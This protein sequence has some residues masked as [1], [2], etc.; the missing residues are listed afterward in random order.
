MKYSGWIIP[1]ITLWI[2]MGCAVA[3][4][5]TPSPVPTP[6]SSPTVMVPTPTGSMATK[7][8]NRNVPANVPA[9]PGAQDLEGPIQFVW[10]GIEDVRQSTPASNWTYY[11]CNVSPSIL[12]VFYRRWMS[13][14]QYQWVLQHWEERPTATLGV[15]Y[16]STSTPGVP[17]RWLYLWFL[18]DDSAK[19]SSYL[20]SAWWEAA[21]S[22]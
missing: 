18:P 5:P 19:Q 1:V 6:A 16:S 7:I 13:E 4:A 12:A 9:C 21:K 15:F 17:N 22:C 3:P 8:A 11:H 10:T 2:C 14:P 20:V